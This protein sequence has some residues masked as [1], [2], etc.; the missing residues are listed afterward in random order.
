MAGK[1]RLGTIG[2][3]TGAAA[4]AAGAFTAF[5]HLRYHR[6]ACASLVELGSGA[7]TSV[8]GRILGRDG[9]ERMVDKPERPRRLFFPPWSRGR[10]RV[11]RTGEEAMPVYRL[12]P[13]APGAASDTI[14]LYLHGGGYIFPASP[15][16]VL[17][18]DG[19]ARRTGAEFVVPLPPL[20]PHHTWQEVHALVLDL[21]QRILEEDPGRRVVLMGDSSGGNLAL[22]M[23]LTAAQEGVRQ[24]DELVLISPWVDITHTN[25]DI[26]RYAADDPTMAINGLT[27]MGRMWAGDTPTSDW[28]LSPIN[29]ELSVLRKVTTFVGTRETFLPDDVLLH[30][31][32][33][34]AGVESTLHV[35]ENLNHVYPMIPAPEGRRAR[36][37]IARIVVGTA[38]E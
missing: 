31:K 20:S 7:Y 4:A 5:S 29:G 26:E 33:V 9:L 38:G 30:D 3:L 14:V 24:P 22:A 17:L 36:R 21:Y 28:H 32:L 10:Y 18:V 11:E 16:H 1:N 13:T 6:S 15:G 2:I 27:T 35:G 25:P 37:E 19:L 34:E 8:V 12:V 23:A